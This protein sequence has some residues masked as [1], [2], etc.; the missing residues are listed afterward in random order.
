MQKENAERC[1]ELTKCILENFSLSEDIKKLY[2]NLE[3]TFSDSKK[4]NLVWP[5]VSTS[6]LM[7]EN[8]ISKQ[9]IYKLI[10]E[11]TYENIFSLIYNQDFIEGKMLTLLDS[12]NKDVNEA[13]NSY[14][15]ED[16]TKFKFNDED[17][18]LINIKN[19]YRLNT[20]KNYHKDRDEIDD[21]QSFDS[22][23]EESIFQEQE[24]EEIPEEL[25]LNIDEDEMKKIFT[26]IDG[27]YGCNK[28]IITND[29][30]DIKKLIIRT[31]NA[32]AHSNYEVVDEN[33]IRMY[34]YDKITK[35]LDFNVIMNKKLVLIIMDELNEIFFNQSKSFFEDHEKYNVEENTKT[36]IS[37]REIYRFISKYPTFSGNAH[38][39]FRRF[40]DYMKGQNDTKRYSDICC[41]ILDF[42]YE[43]FAPNGLIGILVNEY[44]DE[45]LDHTFRGEYITKIATYN[46]LKSDYYEKKNNKYKE[47]LFKLLFSSLLNSYLLT[48]Y[49]I[50]ENKKIKGL[51]F[52]KLKMDKESEKNFNIKHTKLY[53][54]EL[55]ISEEELK[56]YEKE[57]ENV[58]KDLKLKKEIQEKNKILNDYFDNILPNIIKNLENKE[59]LLTEKINVLKFKIPKM[60]L[61][62]LNYNYENDLAYF[63]LRNLRNSLAH[64]TFSFNEPLDM[65]NIE[66]NEIIFESF[67]PSDKNERTFY[68]TIK[69]K[70]LLEIF[71]REEYY[72]NIFEVEILDKTMNRKK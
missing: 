59:I 12:N 34:H 42:M 36:S 4:T 5:L 55:N 29:F 30:L 3:S 62:G 25:L 1:F 31:R 28:A 13:G 64:G 6:F 10:S 27:I 49:N 23:F 43:N 56:R 66:E 24:E 65:N 45:F 17:I 40:K 50:N 32:L 60:K 38:F 7:S 26:P 22:G 72:K 15:F 44:I 33:N 21:F 70:E 52:N 53:E 51:N 46:Y 18:Y 16:P 68:A 11:K 58:K 63:A 2:G 69:V 9:D 37:D 57:L 8:L 20:E 47:D 48:G 39:I 19:E 67:N 41:D 71:L 14:H 61:E 35:E 54:N